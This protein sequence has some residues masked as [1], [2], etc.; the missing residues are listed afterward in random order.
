MSD[1]DNTLGQT[2]DSNTHTNKYSN[3]AIDK[4]ANFDI[5]LDDLIAQK[6]N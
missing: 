3:I 1:N 6:R 2:E 4:L 5:A